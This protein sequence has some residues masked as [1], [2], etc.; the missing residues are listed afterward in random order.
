MEISVQFSRAI[1]AKGFTVIYVTTIHLPICC[2]III[3]IIILPP[4]SIDVFL[5]ADEFSLG[6][7]CHLKLASAYYERSRTST[8]ASYFQAI[9]P[10]HFLVPAQ[11]K[12][13][14]QE[15]TSAS[16]ERKASCRS[17]YGS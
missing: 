9:L 1:A 10:T 17:D 4:H 13:P 8:R 7:G 15:R 3:Q 6:L 16:I 11:T 14:L 12:Q 5:S 2:Q